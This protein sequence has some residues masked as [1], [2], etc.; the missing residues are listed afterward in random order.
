MKTERKLFPL[1]V[2]LTEKKV[3][4]FGGGTIGTRR[5][6]ALLPFVGQLVVIAPEIS[7]KIRILADQGKL[8]YIKKTYDREDLYDADLVLAATDQAS[9]NQDI[10]SACKCLGILVNAANDQTKCD[11]HFP[12]LLAYDGVTIGFNGGGAD[13]KKVKQIRQRVQQLLQE[14]TRE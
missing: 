14:E 10:Y 1:F 12:G 2:D 11:F 6:E 7:E 9:V 5:A 4:I 3:L 13:H 8:Q